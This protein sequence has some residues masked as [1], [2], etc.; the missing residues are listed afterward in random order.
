MS[1]LGEIGSTRLKEAPGLFKKIFTIETLKRGIS[2]CY[3]SYREKY[4][5]TGSIEPAKHLVLYGMLFSYIVA[6]PKERAH[7]KAKQEA[8]LRGEKHH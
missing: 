1:I 4:M 6:L 3:H 5:V 7:H 2:N 8:L